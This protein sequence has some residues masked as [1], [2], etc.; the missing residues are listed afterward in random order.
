MMPIK[1]K[2]TH[3]KFILTIAGP[4][5]QHEKNGGVTWFSVKREV[6]CISRSGSTKSLITK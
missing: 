6:L 1:L 5:R 4:D 2:G 3:N